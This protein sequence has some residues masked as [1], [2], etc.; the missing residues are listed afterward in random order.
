MIIVKYLITYGIN[1]Y[2]YNI[3][4]DKNKS[5]LNLFVDDYNFSSK[6]KVNYNSSEYDFLNDFFQT[7]CKIYEVYKVRTYYVLENLNPTFL[8]LKF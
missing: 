5:P 7:R 3:Q 8:F 4:P 2:L 6:T 1:E